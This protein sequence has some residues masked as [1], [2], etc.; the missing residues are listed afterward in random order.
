MTI[1]QVNKWTTAG[2][3]VRTNPVHYGDEDL[4][5][6]GLRRM[7]H[8]NPKDTRGKT[9]IKIEGIDLRRQ[10][11]HIHKLLHQTKCGSY[12]SL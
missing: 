2:L 6:N 5:L 3:R 9:K 10:A 7:N 1:T 11:L 12:H 4:T 8:E